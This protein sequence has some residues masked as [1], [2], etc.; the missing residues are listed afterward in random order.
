[1][2]A[3]L[4]S[5]PS[6]PTQ[7]PERPSTRRAGD[8]DLGEDVDEHALETADVADDVDR[9]GE[10]EDRVAHELAGAVPRDLPAAVDVDDRGSVGRPLLG[11]GALPG[12]VDGGVLQK[13]DGVGAF[14][15]DDRAM[16]GALK[17]ETL[18]VRHGVGA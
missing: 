16:D 1:M 7:T 6:G 5:A 17:V 13:D 15:P 12:G 3:I 8:A 4:F 14:A 9:L 11:S 2:A 18:D 10:P